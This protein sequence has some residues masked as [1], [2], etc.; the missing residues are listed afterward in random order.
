MGAVL[1]RGEG[2]EFDAGGG[3]R[4]RSVEQNAYERGGSGGSS[5]MDR[6]RSRK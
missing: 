3:G 2:G 1:E 4:W 6:S 5:D